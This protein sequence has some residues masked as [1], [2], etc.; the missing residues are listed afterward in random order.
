MIEVNLFERLDAEAAR[1]MTEK[2]RE[3]RKRALA[4]LHRHYVIVTDDGRNMQE[5][6]FEQ[7]PTIQEL[8]ARIGPDRWVVSVGM[9]RRS[10]RNLLAAE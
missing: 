7:P 10:L 3:G 6:W 4:A 9:R 1:R 2:A 5:V 8:L